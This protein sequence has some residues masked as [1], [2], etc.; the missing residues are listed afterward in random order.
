MLGRLDC[1]NDGCLLDWWPATNGVPR[2]SLMCPL[3]FVI[4]INDLKNIV[5]NLTNKIA[6]DNSIKSVVDS[7]EEHRSIKREL[8]QLEQWA[9][10]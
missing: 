8:G 3:L 7:E 2:G 4:S 6:D 10:I 5:V 1:G 9:E